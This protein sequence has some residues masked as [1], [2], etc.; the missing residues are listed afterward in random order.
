VHD[1]PVNVTSASAGLLGTVDELLSPFTAPDHAPHSPSAITLRLFAREAPPLPAGRADWFSYPP[2]R[3]T[4]DARHGYSEYDGHYV[5]RLTLASGAI[6]V[7]APPRLGIDRW[8]LAHAIVLPLLLEALRGHGLASLHAAALCDGGRAVLLPG[9]SGSG[10][11]TLSVALVHGGFALLADDAPFA[12][13]DADGIMLC[14]FAEPVNVTS[15]T[16]RLLPK[17]APRWRAVEPDARGKVGFTA[18]DL[19]GVV[20]QTV[21]AAVVIFPA[22]GEDACSWVTPLAK[23]DALLR[24]LGMSMPAST[25]AVGREQFLLLADLVRQAD[26]Y[27]LTAGRDFDALPGLVRRLLHARGEKR[28]QSHPSTPTVKEQA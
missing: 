13:R 20:E 2:L 26:C 10:K 8:M 18:A 15:A 21:P 16:A 4:T 9:A 1:V 17:L 5:A 24:L 3:C 23:S 28:D 6:T 27:T 19:G 11:S 7:W 14:A 22:I 12:R 25:A